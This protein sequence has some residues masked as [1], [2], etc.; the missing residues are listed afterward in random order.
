MGCLTVSIWLVDEY[1]A[2]GFNTCKC[3]LAASYRRDGGKRLEVLVE[4]LRVSQA[5][6]VVLYGCV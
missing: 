1:A 3:L 6:V 4:E 2:A 5:L